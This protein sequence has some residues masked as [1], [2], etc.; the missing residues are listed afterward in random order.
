MAQ[1]ERYKATVKASKGTPPQQDF[2][3]YHAKLKAEQSAARARADS[4]RCCRVPKNWPPPQKVL[5]TRV[6]CI[7]LFGLPWDG[8]FRHLSTI[9]EAGKDG[10]CIT[11]QLYLLE[12]PFLL[13]RLLSKGGAVPLC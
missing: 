6:V 5:F 12:R 9:C 4:V 3:A 7:M 1:R 2:S 8:D 13:W 11:T 10:C